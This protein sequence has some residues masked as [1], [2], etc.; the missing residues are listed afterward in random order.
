[1]PLSENHP[2]LRE[3]EIF[4]TN[5]SCDRDW[6]QWSSIGLQTKRLGDTAYDVY[7][8]VIDGM[9]P[10]FVQKDEHDQNL[11]SHGIDPETVADVYGHTEIYLA[12]SPT[13]RL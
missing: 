4:L 1:M 11:L 3:G 2:E 5:I 6:L 10:V 8:H 13:R 12:M 9:Q 7:D